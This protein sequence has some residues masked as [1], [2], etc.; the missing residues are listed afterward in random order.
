MQNIYLFSGPCGCGKST[1][2]EAFAKKADRQIYLLHGDDFHAGFID[3]EDTSLP[4]TSW[5]DIL[6]FNWDCLLTV[7]RKALSMGLDVAI[8]YVVEDELPLVKAL[9]DEYGA[10]LH[11]IVLTAS[12]ETLCQRL[13]TRGDAWLTERALFLKRKLEH[14]PE[15]Q[16]HLL[17]ITGMNLGEEITQITLRSFRI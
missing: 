17:D 3:P 12:E 7:A 14:M 9:A 15:N 10:A 16:S 2:V 1:L 4:R 6:R 13:Q 5:E 8:D 11:Y